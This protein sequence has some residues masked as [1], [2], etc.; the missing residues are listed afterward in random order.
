MPV[1]FVKLT[2]GEDVI[3]DTVVT[4]Q[5]VTLKS[6]VQLIMTPQG[7]IGMAHF[8]PFVKDKEIKITKEYVLFTGTPDAEILNA[9]NKQFGTG[10]VTA[11]ASQGILLGDKV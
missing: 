7:G 11:T 6:P 10:I 1:L 2:S 3:A 8:C 5:G 4:E 9:Y